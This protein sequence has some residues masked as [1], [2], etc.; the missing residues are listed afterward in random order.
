MT[1]AVGRAKSDQGGAIKSVKDGT[2]YI[3]GNLYEIGQVVQA[4]ISTQT[5]SK[6]CPS[7]GEI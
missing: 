5:V 7:W 3:F 6:S 1:C 2:W 4:Y